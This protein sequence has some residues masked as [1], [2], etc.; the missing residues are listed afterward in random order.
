VKLGVVYHQFVRRGGL[1]GYLL[2]F[3]SELAAAGH[4][5]HLAG[6]HA[7]DEFRRLASSVQIFPAAFTRAST[8]QH[9]AA[10]TASL[11]TTWEVD[12]ILGFGR[13]FRQDVHRAGGGCHA[14]YS[15][16]LP[17]WKR[18]SRK[19]RTELNLERLLYTSGQTP[20]FVVNAHKVAQELT[21]FHR[22]APDAIR[23]IHT[24]VDTS[25]W[26]PA[27][28]RSGRRD[29][30]SLPRNAPL[31]LFVSLD[32][33]RKGL[34][35]LLAALAALPRKDVHLAVA[36]KPLGPWKSLIASLGLTRRVH[37]AGPQQ[38]LRPWYQ[39]ADLF[40]HP[41]RYDACANTVL[42]SMAS[43]LPGIISAEDG[44]SEFISHGIN[45]WILNDPHSPRQLAD[46]IAAALES[47]LADIGL[48]ARESMVPLTWPHHLNSWIPLLHEARSLR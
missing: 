20:R 8:L 31:L 5:L 19:N 43:A 4:S 37:E 42:Q 17:W 28:D 7:D 9:F 35:T 32:H 6:V 48:R 30:L 45:G 1:E 16:D 22:V 36:G 14:R 26:Q 39:S 46:L 47:P 21:A 11:A 18:W 10:A 2:R 3:C 27:P 41:S 23:V 38:D 15:R 29:A 25:H 24:A 34:P 12:A 33:R 40:V 13:T 44:A